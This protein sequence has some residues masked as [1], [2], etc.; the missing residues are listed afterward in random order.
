MYCLA[1]TIVQQII[2]WTSK[3]TCDIDIKGSA[4]QG[5]SK[6]RGRKVSPKT[7]ENQALESALLNGIPFVRNEKQM[8]NFMELC[9]GM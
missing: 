6:R 7:V 3:G 8:N 2:T 5:T 9:R 1:V 4:N